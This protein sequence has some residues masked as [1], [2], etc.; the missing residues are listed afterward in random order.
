MKKTIDQNKLAQIEYHGSAGTTESCLMAVSRIIHFG[1]LINK[2]SLLSYFDGQSGAHSLLLK[3][4]DYTSIAIKSGFSSGYNGEGPRGLSTIL[5]MLI[6]HNVEID[7]YEINSDIHN[8]IDASCLLISDLELLEE[9]KPIRP[10]RY[11]DYIDDSK[12][13]S[14]FSNDHLKKYFPPSINFG[15]L[16]KRLIDLA[17]DFHENTDHSISSAFRRL[18]DTIRSRTGLL[19][20]NGSKLFTKAFEGENSIL[21][22]GN[23]DNGEHAG[24]SNLFKAVFSAYRNPRA[25]REIKSDDHDSL[26]EFMLI[27]ELFILEQKAYERKN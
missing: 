16:D 7:E 12:L 8:R 5:K 14:E 6:R 18:E 20:E 11:Y 23:T 21:Y 13:Q 19:D 9:K 25:H 15:L 24:K 1:D 27:N 17:L 2:A 26:R 22:W 4:N 3:V 10:I